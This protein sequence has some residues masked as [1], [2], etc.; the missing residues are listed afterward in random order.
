MFH[1]VAALEW[2]RMMEGGG[3]PTLSYSC[4]DKNL[5]KSTVRRLISDG[6]L[7]LWF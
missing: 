4:K 3:T 2:K 1:I 5:S 6:I 7:L